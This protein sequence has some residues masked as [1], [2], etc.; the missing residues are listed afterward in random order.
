MDRPR[1]VLV[2]LALIGLAM[3]GTLSRAE[4]A[5][6]SGLGFLAPQD[7]WPQ[8]TAYGIS[9]DGRVI[10]GDSLSGGDFVACA[11]LYIAGE[12]RWEIVPL[13]GLLGNSAYGSARAASGDGSVI[14]GGGSSAN[15]LEA[16]RW[17]AGA[18]MVG[19]GDLIG[20]SF[21]S[22]AFGVSADG[23]VVV[24][25]SQSGSGWEAFRWTAGAGMVGLGDLAGGGFRSEARAVSADGSVVVGTSQSGSGTE[26]FRWTLE[27]GMAGLSDLPGGIFGSAARAVSADGSVVVGV[28]QSGS[29]WEAFRWTVGAGIV[30]LGDLP[31]GAFDS[32]ARAASADG[33]VVV[34]VGSSA[35]GREAFLWTPQTGMRSLRSVLTGEYG[36][37]L[38]GWTLDSA[39]GVSADG[40]TVVGIGTNPDGNTEA[41]VAIL[42][43]AAQDTTPPVLTVPGDLVVEQESP[44]GAAVTWQCTATDDQGG[45]VTIVCT[46][47]SGGVLPLGQ[48]TVTCTA[49]DGAGNQA[50][51]T[52]TITVR[53]SVPPTLIGPPDIT[54]EEGGPSG[55][56]VDLG[57]PTAGDICDADVAVPNDAPALFPV[58]TTIVTWTATDDSGNTSRAQ[59]RVTVVPTSPVSQLENLAEMLQAATEAGAMLPAVQRS[60]MVK[61]RA[62]M[63]ALAPGKPNGAKTAWNQLGAFINEVRAQ[64]GKKIER[65]VAAELI[66]S[67]QQIRAALRQ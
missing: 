24:G 27:G 30:G 16:F 34:G 6:F 61:L 26:A 44:A 23:S 63:V 36:L 20:G 4:E 3:G 2:G 56:P 58:G 54:V 55:T 7:A 43:A 39:E 12:M 64:A 9:A 10:V 19:L 67:A 59:Q 8:S 1:K 50:A 31:G 48:T 37:N 25:V 42:G 62:A 38:T 11:W 49:T 66:E 32:E 15:G 28:S 17:T 57:T 60:L 35:D 33:S 18:G 46:P 65:G 14:I 22:E 5:S 51:G 53:D 40:R 45:N 41:W 29:G 13:G 52:F 47:S 21:Q